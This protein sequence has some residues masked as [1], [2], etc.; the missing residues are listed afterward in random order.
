MDV[1]SAVLHEVRLASVAYRRLELRAPYRL[2]FDQPE[3]RGVHVILRGRCE[4]LVPKAPPRL[5]EPGDLVLLPRA[6]AHV[7][8][9][10]GEK[11]APLVSSAKVAGLASSAHVQF[12]GTGPETIVLCGAFFFQETNHPALAALPHVLHVPAEVGRAQRWLAAY[13]DALT[14]ELFEGGPGSEMVMARLSDALVA[15]ALRYHAEQTSAASWLGALSDPHLARALSALHESIERPWSLPEL[16]RIA[17]LSRAAF[18]A[19]FAAKVGET[20]M[21]Y[22]L[23]CRVQRAMALLREERA[24]L[25]SVAAQVGYGSEAALSVAFKRHTGVAPG[26]YRRGAKASERGL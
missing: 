13:I 21:R 5:L 23:R 4:L 25:A 2:S 6:D 9:S 26:A 20:P 11:R 19:R 8:R 15:R 14:T 16:A 10:V 17:G 22:L 18:A 3:V 1:L 24:T 7:L 12:G